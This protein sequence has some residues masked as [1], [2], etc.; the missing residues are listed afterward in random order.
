MRTWSSLIAGPGWQRAAWLA[1][2]MPAAAAC[3]PTGHVCRL[4][5]SP[6]G[7]QQGQQADHHE[8]KYHR[9]AQDLLQAVR[10][11]LSQWDRLV[12]RQ[13]GEYR[14]SQPDAG[15]LRHERLPDPVQRPLPTARQI[16]DGC[17]TRPAPVPYRVATAP[18]MIVFRVLLA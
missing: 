8:R 1:D 9:A 13:P 3:A 2:D 17:P 5:I 12:P 15:I 7:R 14:E 16:H 4:G 11:L 6:A 10:H 18:A